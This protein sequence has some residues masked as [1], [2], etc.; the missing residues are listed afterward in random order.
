MTARF[1]RLTQ[2]H[3]RIDERLRLALR[4]RTPDVVEVSRLAGLKARAKAALNRM[5]MR[6]VP[7]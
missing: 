4:K 7:A 2:I 6:A 3:Q 5:A 1:F